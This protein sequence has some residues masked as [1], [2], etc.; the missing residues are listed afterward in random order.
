MKPIRLLPLAAV[1]ALA[2]CGG[3]SSEPEASAPAAPAVAAIDTRPSITAYYDANG[4][5]P[6]VL[7]DPDSKPTG[8]DIDLLNAIGDKQGFRVIYLPH[9]FTGIFNDLGNGVDTVAGGVTVTQERKNQMDFTESYFES[10]P[11]L[12]LTKESPIVSFAE[13]RGKNIA[14]VGSTATV[15]MVANIQ[16]GNGRIVEKQTTWDAVRSTLRKETDG[17]F[18]DIGPLTYYANQYK[19]LGA[20]V[21]VDASMPKDFYAFP[22]KRG[23]DKLLQQLNAGL[24]QVRADGTYDKLYQKW[25]ANAASKTAAPAAPAPQPAS[26]AASAAQPAQ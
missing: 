1:F 7:S 26:A 21:I 18:G 6:F 15:A 2:A 11:A 4:F 20:R 8:F 19:E 10:S 25:F 22:V 17:T 24:Q 23:D 13:M 9:I 3:N 5:V 16:N 14:V 12:L